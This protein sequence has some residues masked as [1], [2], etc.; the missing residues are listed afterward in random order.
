MRVFRRRGHVWLRGEEDSGLEVRGLDLCSLS[1]SM[2]VFDANCGDGQ[3]KEVRVYVYVS[4]TRGYKCATPIQWAE[5]SG[6]STRRW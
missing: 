5:L 2:G 1:A 6:A 4:Q 3:M